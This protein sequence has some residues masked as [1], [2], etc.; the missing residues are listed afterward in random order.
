[1]EKLLYRIIL[2]FIVVVV[3]LI[4]ALLIGVTGHAFGLWTLNITM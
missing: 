2:C 1:M 3:V 4:T